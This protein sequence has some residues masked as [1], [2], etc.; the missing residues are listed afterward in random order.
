MTFE[1]FARAVAAQVK[2][3]AVDLAYKVD[4][5]KLHWTRGALTVTLFEDDGRAKVS[6]WAVTTALF[7]HRT[8]LPGPP[9]SIDAEG[10][11]PAAAE[12]VN[13]RFLYD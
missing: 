9:Y 2:I 12:I 5:A 11:G 7:G 1:D 8:G 13:D 6:Y 10:I 4:P 3:T